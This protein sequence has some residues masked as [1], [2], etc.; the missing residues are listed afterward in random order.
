LFPFHPASKTKVKEER[1]KREKKKRRTGH[2]LQRLTTMP[3]PSKLLL[4]APLQSSNR[5][6][7]NN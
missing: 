3:S 1:N 6:P 4:L 5:F 2:G 7:A